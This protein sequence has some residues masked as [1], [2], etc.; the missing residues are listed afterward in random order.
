MGHCFPCAS[1]FKGGKGVATS[2]GATAVVFPYY[3]PVDVAVAL[4][5]YAATKKASIATVAASS[6]F[7]ALSFA[8]W[9]RKLPNGW[10]PRPTAMLPVFAVLTSAVIA[11]KF[12][13]MPE[14]WSHVED[15]LAEAGPDAA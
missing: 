9:L 10:G 11:Y 1:G 7:V 8:W 2:A 3:A 15:E 12:M 14:E 6:V 5:G 13:T 4:L